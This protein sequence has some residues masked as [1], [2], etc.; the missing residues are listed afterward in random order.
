MAEDVAAS[1]PGVVDVSNNLRVEQIVYDRGGVVP[2]QEGNLSERRTQSTIPTT[3]GSSAAVS[4]GLNSYAGV[5]SPGNIVLGMR[6]D[7]STPDEAR[8]EG[9]TPVQQPPPEDREVPPFDGARSIEEEDMNTEEQK[10]GSL[11][12]QAAVGSGPIDLA[13][14]RSASTMPDWSKEYPPAVPPEGGPGPKLPQ[15]GPGLPE[16]A[17]GA[18]RRQE[19]DE[20]VEEETGRD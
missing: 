12:R 15:T 20:D 13:G 11:G 7:P 5:A 17:A 10:P 4:R 8:G 6:E 1:V 14:G 19:T 2:V 18:S 16:S 3:G 9:M